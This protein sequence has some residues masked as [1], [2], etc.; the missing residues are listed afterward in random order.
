MIRSSELNWKAGVEVY[1]GSPLHQNVV[2]FL[3][4]GARHM[5]GTGHYS[6]SG[7]ER[8]VWR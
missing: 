7:C 6:Q 2:E 4:R 3:T 1:F 8:S 5:E